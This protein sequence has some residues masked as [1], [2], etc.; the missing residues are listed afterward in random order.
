[1]L[2]ENRPSTSKQSENSN[3][4]G[5]VT[6]FD[7]DEVDKNETA[8]QPV[9]PPSRTGSA[10]HARR[11]TSAHR[12][13][14]DG[15]FEQ[16]TSRPCTASAL[17]LS[18]RTPSAPLFGTEEHKSLER[19]LTSK[20]YERPKSPPRGEVVGDMQTT[21]SQGKILEKFRRPPM[22]PMGQYKPVEVNGIHSDNEQLYKR[23]Q[24][25]DF[26]AKQA[27][28]NASLNSLSNVVSKSS[29]AIADYRGKQIAMVNNRARAITD[30]VIPPQKILSHTD[31]LKQSINTASE[32]DEI[33]KE[34]KGIIDSPVE[35]KPKVFSPKYT[36][37]DIKFGASRLTS[38]VMTSIPIENPWNSVSS[39]YNVNFAV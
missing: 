15:K 7:I 19:F 31:Q 4:E 1:L 6:M 28:A 5:I 21:Q 20:F 16:C 8:F 36:V 38:G 24:S 26:A 11:L 3:A 10:I 37:P 39:T 34:S 27:L 29:G 17:N 12:V 22:T 9:N 18:K 35:L 23:L 33:E 14:L 30:H 2:N 13:V 25:A 32:L